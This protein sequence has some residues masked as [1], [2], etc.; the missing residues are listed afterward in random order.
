MII[1]FLPDFGNFDFIV[2]GSGAAGAVVANRLSEIKKWK[3]LLL[4]AGGEPVDFLKIVGLYPYT[5]YSKFNWGY[6]TTRQKN[7]C[8]GE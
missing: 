8:L 4:E 3:V 7:A 1:I 2:V 6:N 5:M